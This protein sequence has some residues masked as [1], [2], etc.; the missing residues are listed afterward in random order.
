MLRKCYSCKVEKDI[1]KFV[2][3]KSH[4]LGHKYLCLSCNSGKFI[5]YY[6]LHRK[7]LNE[8]RKKYS[9]T[10]KGKDVI[11]RA[12]KKA[13]KNHTQK[14]IARAKLRYAVKIGKVTKLSCW[15]GNPKTDGH[16]HKGYTSEHELDV[17]WLCRPHHM[18]LHRK[19][20]PD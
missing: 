17:L 13:Y 15:C 9:K 1:T 19:Y 8:E 20:Q 2:S 5:E 6:L 10:E 7:K 11:N 18:E 16:H 12:S 14:W 4:S 3:D